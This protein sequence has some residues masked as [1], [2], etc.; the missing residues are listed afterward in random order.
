MSGVGV[1][2]NPAVSKAED[3]QG[4][5]GAMVG[6]RG[7]FVKAMGLAETAVGKE[8]GVGG[9]EEY[10]VRNVNYMAKVEEHSISAA[11]NTEGASKSITNED[12]EAAETYDRSTGGI[13]RNI[14]VY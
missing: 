13:S 2:G 1:N 7:D 10:M 3:A 4:A 6:L 12:A 9:Y 8:P 5:A 14:N 11:E